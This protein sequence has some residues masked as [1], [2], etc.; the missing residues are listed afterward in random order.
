MA[1]ATVK[2]SSSWSTMFS[3]ILLDR[4]VKS[5][6]CSR[7]HS[8]QGHRGA[9]ASSPRQGSSSPEENHYHYHY[10]YNHYHYYYYH[11]Y[12]HCH[13]YYYYYHH[14]Y[15]YQVAALA[16]WWEHLP[17]TNVALARF[18]HPVSYEDWVCW[19]S[20][21]PWGV[22]L[23][24]L[25]FSLLIKNQHLICFVNNNCKIK[26]WAMLI[27]FPLELLSAFDH[28]HMLIC[29]IEILNIKHN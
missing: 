16:K 20:T 22:S 6:L 4:I 7:Q 1:P 8:C 13:H 12:Y 14:Y 10:Y 24:V 19:F 15:Y 25:R 5:F 11:Y 2:M 23:R 28:I 27:W 3:G 21:L 9:Q 18:P 17:S 26:I 29:A